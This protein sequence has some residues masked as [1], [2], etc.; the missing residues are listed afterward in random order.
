M[1]GD[2]RVL[3][4][5]AMLGHKVRRFRQAQGLTQAEML[6]ICEAFDVETTVFDLGCNA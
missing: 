3:D 6:Q 1:E 2:A 5:K 4:K